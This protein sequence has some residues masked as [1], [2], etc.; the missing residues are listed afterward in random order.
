MCDLTQLSVSELLQLNSKIS[1]EL[2]HRLILRSANNPTGDYGEWLFSQAYGWRLENNA[3]AGYDA[4]DTQGHRVQIKC[5]RLTARNPSRLLSSIRNLNASP[6][7]QLAGVLLNENY[8][9]RRAALIPI[10]IIRQNAVFNAHVN[11]HRFWLRD[12]VW[13][14]PGVIDVTDKLKT[15][16]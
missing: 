6:F 2:R 7:E 15:L 5:R 10:D 13:D 12:T 9:V 14:I 3:N 1:D 11:G 16:S 8:S 4:I